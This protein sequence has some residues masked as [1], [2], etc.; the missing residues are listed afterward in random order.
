LSTQIHTPAKSKLTEYIS[1]IWEIR[2]K[3]KVQETIL[4][5]GVMEIVFNLADGMTAT[6]TQSNQVIQPARCFVQGLNTQTLAVSYAGQ[7]HLFGIRL[8][9]HMVKRLLGV[10]PAEIK[11]R[12]ADLNLIDSKMNYLWNQLGEAADFEERVRVIEQTFP[13][14]DQEDCSRTKKLADLFYSESIENFQSM[15]SLAQQ[16]YYSTRHLNRKSHNLF[17]VSAEELIRYKK[18]VHSTNLIH[19]ED[20]SMTEIALQSGFYDQAHFC[21]TFKSFAHLTPLQYKSQKSELPFHIFS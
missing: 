13:I 7:H 2:G 9:P 21:K 3:K 16:V 11:D 14:L 19:R 1:G 6:Q 4:P 17:G 10:T 12:I 20:L 18:F 5:Q 15:D 8:K